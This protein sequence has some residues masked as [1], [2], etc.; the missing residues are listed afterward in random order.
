MSQY[1]RR[2]ALHELKY[3]KFACE[4]MA[5]AR[6]PRL[7]RFSVRIVTSELFLAVRTLLVELLPQFFTPNELTAPEHNGQGNNGSIMGVNDA[8]SVSRIY[9][10]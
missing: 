1:S 3:S 6:I 5:H 10:P 2:R 7:D 8:G 4:D 9:R